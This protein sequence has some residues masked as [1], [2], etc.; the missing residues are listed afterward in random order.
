MAYSR[1]VGFALISWLMF[2]CLDAQKITSIDCDTTPTTL[3][4][5]TF[6]DEYTGDIEQIINIPPNVN[7][8]LR[9]FLF[10]E[11]LD[12]V[13]L[14][15][16]SSTNN[17]TVKTRKPLDVDSIESD[18]LFYSIVCQRSGM[19]EIE[20]ARDLQLEDVNDNSPEFLQALYNTSVSEVSAINSIVIKVEAQDKDLSPLFSHISY[21]L[22]GPNSDYF[23]IREGDGN[24]MVNK[25]LDY[26]KVKHFNLTVQAKER[27]GNNSNTVS[28]IIDVQDY[29]TLNPYFSQ[30]VYNGAIS[31]NKLGPLSILPEKIFA[32]DGDTGINEKVYYS[33]KLVKPPA[34]SNTFSINADSG[35]LEVKTAIDREECPYLIVGIEAA[36]QDN[37]L[38]TVDA[39][40]LVT[41]EDVNDNLPVFSQSSYNVSIL[42]NFP[43]GKE[44][45]RVEAVDKDEGGF[46]GMFSLTPA[47]S[48]FQ[49]SQDGI[50]TVRNSTLLDRE[51]IPSIH[52]QV[53][54][55]DHLSPYDEAQS[56]INILLLDE[57][58][59]SPT[60]TDTRYEQV[61]FI[62]M[63]AGMPILQVAA[64]DPDDGMN[65]EIS[66]VLAGGNEDGYFELDKATGQI[67]LKAVIPL[68]VNE[69]KNFVLWVTATDGGTNPRSSSVPVHIFAVG[70]SRPQFIQKTYNVSVKEELVSPVEVARVKYE[71]L[72]PHIPVILSVLTESATFDVDVNG[73]IWTK[74]KLDY[75]SQNN[76]TLNISLSDGI[77][78]DYATVFIQVTD[79]NDNSPVFGVTNTTIKILENAPAGTSVTSVPATDADSGFNGLVVYALKGAEEKM[80][81]DGSG[82]IL[83]KKELDRETQDIYNLEVIASDQ[84]Q[85]RLSTVLSV[86][87]VID[88]VNDNPP[89]FSSSIYEVSVPEDKAHGSELLTVSATDLDAGTNALVKYRIVSQ[90]PLTS[91][92][93][94]L[95]NLTSGQFFLNQQLD[96]ETTKQFEVEVEASDGGQPSLNT[97]THVVIRVLDVNDNPPKFNQ[98]TYDIAVVENIEKGSPI[99]TFSVTDDDEAGFSQGR[100]IHNSTFFT[101]DIPGVLSLRND[102]EL[103]RETTPGFTLQVWAVD[104]EKD[105]LNSSSFFHITVLDVNDNNPEFQ[106]QSYRFAVLE[107]DY[108]LGSPPVV[109]RVTATD[110]DEGEN[111]RISYR[112]SSEDG[113]NPYVIQQDGTILVNGYVDRETKEKYELLL[114]ASDNGMPQRQNF[115][116][117]SI[118]VLDVNDNV[119]LFT[120]MHYSASIRVA[121]AKEGMFVLSVS[122]TDL[123]IGNNSVISYSL[124]NHSDIFH[125]NNHTGEIILISSL[126]HITADT[127]VTLTVI[128]ADHGVPQL[129]SNV[130]V[131]VYLLVND[132][133]F[134]LAFESSSYEFSIPEEEPV[135][136]VV[137][138]VK[139]LTGSIAIQVAY[140][141][142]SHADNFAISDQGDIV[143]LATLDRE[144]DDLYSI[145]V[146][147]V[148]SVVPPNT[149]IALV[150]VRVSD[151]NDNPPVFSKSIQT[152]LSLPENAAPLDLG[153][154]SATDLDIGDNAFISYNLQDDFAGTFHINTSTGVLTTGTS[155]DRET[156][157]NYE[158]IIIA[159]DSGK[160]PLSTSL[161][162]SIAVEDVN[163]NP[164][165][166]S[167]KSYSVTVK[168]NDP[169]H[170]ILSVTATDKDMGYNAIIHY[171]IIEETSFHVGEFSG[172]ISTVQPLDYE[173]C[174]YYTFTLKAFN[175]GEPH[176]QDIA[177]ITVIVEDVNEE[178]PMFDKPS[179]F[180]ILPD[181]STAG[182]LVVDI[183]ARDE[184]K[185]YD[186]G[187]F[188]N[189]T[190]GNSERLFNLSS[191]SGVLT[192]TRDLNKQALPLY[193]SLAVTATDSG[194]PPLSTSVKVSVIIAPTNISFPVFSEAVYQPA[195]LSEKTLPDTFVVQITA[196][197]KVPVIYSIVSGDEKGYFI[198]NPSTGIIRT[199][200][201]LTVEDF[202]FFFSVRA[203]D[204]STAS[205]YNEV[206]VYVE[207]IDE[208][209]FPPVFTSSLLEQ[210]LEENLP[211]TQIVHLIARDNDTGRN[212]VLTYGIL[213]GDG[214][215][216]RIDEAT[217]ILYSTVSF[218]Y[219]EEPTEYQVVIYAEDDG[220]PEKKRGYCTVVVKI[221]DVNDWP[222]VF[223]PVT[224][225]SVNENVDVEFVVGKVT[226]TDRDTGDNAFV[227]YS[228]TG[229]GGEIFEIDA[230]L[231]NIKIKNSPDYEN[232]NKYT[233][234]VNAVNNKSAPFYQATTNVTVLVVDVN[235]NAPV[236]AQT[237]YSA[238]INMINPV[239][240]HVIT[241]HAT[242]KDQGQNGLI[243]Y[244]IIPDLNFSVFFLIEDESEGKIITTGNLSRVEEIR[245]TVMAKDKGSPSLN[246]TAVITLNVTDNRPFVPQFIENKISISVVENTG[247]DHSIYTFAVAETSGKSIVYTIVSGNEEGHFRL[248]P[249]SGQLKTAIN[250]N[251]EEVSQHVIL[252]EANEDVSSAAQVQSSGLFAQNVVMLTIA[253]QD[254]NEKPEFLNSMYS[255]LIP[256]SVPYKYPVITVQAT[257]PDAGGNGLL[258]YSL[259]NYQEEFDVN[260]NTGQIYTVFLA[261]RA[262]SVFLELQAADQ[263]G[264][265]AR[266]T[267]NAT[268]YVTSSSNIVVFVLNQ[269][270][271]AVER[272]I[273]EVKRVLEE[274]LEWNV[275][276]V[277]VYSNDVERTARNT[278]NETFI[279][280]IAIDNANGEIP[281]EDVKRKLREQQENI[282]IELEKIF[283]APV[284]TA[285]EEGP[286][287][288]VTPELIATIV[289]SVLL[290]CTL[291]AFL[292]YIVFSITRKRRHGKKQMEMEG[293]D[294]PSMTDKNGSLKNIV[295]L[296]GM[297]DVGMEAVNNMEGTREGGVEDI[298]EAKG[299]QSFLEMLQLDFD[300]DGEENAVLEGATEPRNVG[301]ETTTN[302]TAKQDH[303]DL[304]SALSLASNPIKHAPQ[305]EL[306]GVTFSEVAII[307]DAK[308][309]KD[310]EEEEEEEDVFPQ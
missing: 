11:H 278:I 171:T 95:V 274:K 27:F 187:I 222:P 310:E 306:K 141:L 79:V 214:T 85:P 183:D 287:F 198:I 174:A 103:D 163:D 264:L 137:G 167:Q 177:N 7:L 52:L 121:T 21:S 67:S 272:N 159:T 193:Y 154:F 256:S 234:T 123:D 185:G 207:V 68:R 291:I 156:M 267:V 66:F 90:K 120:K 36:Q 23:Y 135:W 210:Q 22:W 140:F 186:E 126:A 236:F 204:S 72:N 145:V 6:L 211:A 89:V 12:Y 20:N 136:T 182:T 297:N 303:S 122:A 17:A 250:L 271:N 30:S 232:V 58:D 39:I 208:N 286:A 82:L 56:A 292:I 70:D 2:I 32:K 4:L 226:A 124:E 8:K 9:E 268:I 276:I 25:T 253:V 244:Y 237:S 227:L 308:L 301:A 288:S 118:Q 213:S 48:P 33:I 295:K 47:D 296:E 304:G 130:S 242:D 298:P 114:V 195:P 16:D 107:G 223:N 221:T 49:I 50:L 157:D 252:V 45:L 254:V 99:C 160:P 230:I 13:E 158:L 111:A 139:A 104:A 60:F 220:I 219:E 191:T 294:N 168:E 277:E 299:K 194:L 98:A 106:M 199:G 29:D 109:G 180:Q 155:L 144:D 110:L 3:Q 41:I 181:N 179:Y 212:G 300:S 143:T 170:V 305:K 69:S 166:F 281:A 112:L 57:N 239:G 228:L 152:K 161:A 44:V 178:G 243:E 240:A 202:P 43:N 77:T 76:Y 115:T 265:T 35:I 129:A 241:V 255:A 62:N 235:D 133:G 127:V 149:A 94:F 215:K 205:I 125:I 238:S 290:A 275:Y 188:Y 101:V 93:V 309:E 134:G 206:S 19:N 259:L 24:I 151:I 302:I 31:E 97:S 148:D 150:T 165:V 197:Y 263:G 257:D 87:V 248:D 10:P 113:D 15:Y 176:L 258:T 53:T 307:L 249:R 75:E 153:T 218:D 162:L 280:I 184:S 203:T 34:Y 216:F 175:P 217:G 80:D 283:S 54:A 38:K 201:E 260:E 233:L 117:I 28:L 128:A 100:F 64:D 86:T 285:V 37:I 273:D 246:G 14:E 108:R 192:L 63:T 91:S 229:D 172:T 138:S 42:E 18:H 78:T 46:Q 284:T 59:N 279:K 224:P 173:N 71:S 65:G 262:G 196:L 119:P 26:N 251:Y 74:I 269:K 81:I 231:G 190:G 55:R 146:E 83:L 61:I 102:T 132:T 293:V 105:G 270:I 169:P 96:Y 88:D 51:Q 209:D 289:L 247:V 147:A 92:P 200:K 5:S 40:V 1:S 131:T 164:P 282:E 189:I 73:T 142:R 225:F 84:G 116:Y 261:R 266:T 245:L